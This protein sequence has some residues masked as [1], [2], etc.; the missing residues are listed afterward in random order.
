MHI[1]V[2][3]RQSSENLASEN[4][5][6]IE[7]IISCGYLDGAPD[8]HLVDLSSGCLEAYLK[9]GFYELLEDLQCF[10]PAVARLLVVGWCI[11]AKLNTWQPQCWMHAAEVYALLICFSQHKGLIV[12]TSFLPTAEGLLFPLGNLFSRSSTHFRIDLME[13]QRKT[14]WLLDPQLVP[15]QK[16]DPGAEAWSSFSEKCGSTAH[17]G[18]IWEKILSWMNKMKVHQHHRHPSMPLLFMACS[19]NELRA[20]QRHCCLC[21]LCAWRCSLVFSLGELNNLKRSLCL[22]LGNHCH[23]HVHP[24]QPELIWWEVTATS[25]L[26]CACG[27][28][29][30]R[31]SRQRLEREIN[32]SFLQH[33]PN[34]PSTYQNTPSVG[35]RVSSK[36][37]LDLVQWGGTRE[38]G[39]RPRALPWTSSMADVEWMEL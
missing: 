35:Q 19:L 26:W 10:L 33:L 21:T 24:A 32:L 1:V 17:P 6:V 20:Q 23:P 37:G 3:N 9:R 34:Y 5:S 11:E 29:E 8:G 16:T 22:Q 13:W 28:Q 39:V 27:L 25:K 30:H 18:I 4:P 14:G 15:L 12:S 7:N 31:K 2:F 36:D 38:L